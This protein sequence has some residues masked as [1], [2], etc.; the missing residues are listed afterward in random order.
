M[1]AGGDRCRHCPIVPVYNGRFR[2]IQPDIILAD[3]RQQVAAGAQH[4][5]LGDPD[6]FNG[7]GHAVPLVKALHGEF[8]ALTYDV[9][10]KI[11]HLLKHQALLST[12][13]D[14]GCLFVTSAVEA[15]DDQILTIL[16]KGHTR[17]DFV[18]A[19]RLCREVGLVLNPTFVTF[20]PWTT[21][22]G[23][24]DLLTMLDKL[25][26]V[27]HVAPIQYAIRLLLPEGSRLLDVEEV[28]E[29]I[30]P[31]D[32]TA[33]VYPWSH[34]DPQMDDLYET[35]F[36]LVRANQKSG[37]SRRLHFERVW[38]ATVALLPPEAVPSCVSQPA[39]MAV[40]TLSESW[41]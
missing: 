19:V 28:Q 12:L 25:G 30:R 39:E 4:I 17:A 5:T 3:I 27:E 23:Y 15:V 37:E 31:F 8:P 34:S 26:L 38:A 32:Q 21:V 33:L 18:A 2:I 9:T 1:V 20:T 24:V 7:T 16:D 35:V 10:I 14:T 40:P 22:Q 13:R 41:Y 11:E 6:F 36:R 29:M